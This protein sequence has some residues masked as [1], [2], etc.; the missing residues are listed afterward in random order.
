MR[1]MQGED[2]VAEIKVVLDRFVAARLITADTDTVE[3]SHEALLTAW[4]QLRTWL[5]TDRAGL[6]TGRQLGDAAESW[7]R[8]GR[9]P[10]ALYRRVRLATANEWAARQLERLPPLVAEFL[11]E[12]NAHHEEENRRARRRVRR[13]YQIGAVLVVL[14]LVAASATLYAHQLQVSGDRD[15]AQTLSRLV[16]D[17]ANRLRV[18]DPSL[19]AQ[20]AIVGYRISPTPEARSSLLNSTAD[21]IPTR[22]LSPAGKI[23]SATVSSDDRL[24]ATGTRTGLVQLWT[25]ASGGVVS[26][27]ASSLNGDGQ[28]IVSLAFV[29][30]TRILVGG[31][32]GG[33]V[34]LWNLSRPTDPVAMSTPAGPS[35]GILAVAVS[36]D[37]KI[38]AAGGAP[39]DLDTWRPSV[40]WATELHD[41]CNPGYPHATL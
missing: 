31:D 23:E 30:G 5:D 32:K 34:Y 27:T 9:D 17:E 26:R 40:S 8:E 39:Y 6:V 38:L 15:R 10:T 14:V 25:I 2:Q 3:I 20:L 24:L 1:D 4:P 41:L 16:A 28:P 37:G 33:K 36:G 21:A 29:P 22:V 35:G 7:R 13:R 12:S 11:A 18:F 19:S